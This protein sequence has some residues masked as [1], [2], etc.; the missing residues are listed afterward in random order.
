[1]GLL[2]LL[3]RNREDE[4]DE[5]QE[6]SREEG[7]GG[8]LL[9]RLRGMG[10]SAG[11]AL[12]RVLKR[13]GDDDGGE[14]DDDEPVSTPPFREEPGEDASVAAALAAVSASETA[15]PASPAA[16]EP[17]ATGLAGN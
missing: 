4:G 2:D 7:F 14:D 6:E 16:P 11:E 1:M 12:G 3:K 10:D 9:S 5:D 13:G 17:S 15:G 8:G